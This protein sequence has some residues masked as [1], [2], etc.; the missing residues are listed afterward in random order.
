MALALTAAAICL[1]LGYLIVAWGWPG[2]TAG[3]SDLL[4]QA[5]LA[6]GYGLGLFSV[7]FFLAR[8]LGIGHLLVVDAGVLGLGVAAFFLLRGHGTLKPKAGVSGPPVL[9]TQ[10]KSGRERA[11]RESS[12]FPQWLDRV[13][14]ASFAGAVGVALYSAVMRALGHP[15]GVGWDAFA[16]WNLHARFL[17]RGGDQWRDGFGPLIPWSHPDYPLLLPAAVAHFW[18]YL[19]RET[20]AVPAVIGL[21]FTFS[22][23]ALLFSAL[24]ILRGPMHAMLAAIALLTTPTFIEQG[25]WQYADVPL[26]FFFLATVALLCL[27]DDRL[28]E[29]VA[30]RF[31]SLLVLAGL[32]AGLGAWCKNEGVLFL[33]AIIVGRQW[34]AGRNP[35]E[36]TALAGYT[37]A[38]LAGIAP[39]FILVAYFKHFVAPAGDLFSNPGTMLHRVMEAA[40]YW[41]ILQWFVKEFFRF[42]GWLIPGTVVLVGLYFAAGKDDRRTR[43]AGF[44]TSVVALVLTM[45]GYLAVY[46]ITPYE[47]Y[48]HLRSSLPRLFLQLWPSVIFLFFLG[49]PAASQKRA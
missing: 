40:R 38:L 21:V 2:R 47:I 9:P 15:H 27:H 8:V 43:E 17:F 18:T 44:R 12:E 25:T 23:V 20:Q 48:W 7:I 10:A 4:L 24:L 36:R 37:G 22:T 45:A 11:T 13:L 6:A 14:A 31:P 35:G 1:G 41:A 5:S 16:I 33:A 19:G 39:M 28:R 49:T 3:F 32:A 42:G 46:L 26:S 29:G 34:R 30:E